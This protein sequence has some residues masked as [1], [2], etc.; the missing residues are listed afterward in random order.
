MLLS[1]IFSFG[2]EHYVRDP[3][4]G[5]YVSNFYSISWRG[6]IFTV[7]HYFSVGYFRLLILVVLSAADTTLC[8]ASI[9]LIK[10]KKKNPATFSK[11]SD[12]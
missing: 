11:S 9:L 8:S 5:I 10:K 3:T 2:N 4:V 7:W 12:I 6:L 1:L